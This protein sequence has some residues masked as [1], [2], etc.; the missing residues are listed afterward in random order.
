MGHARQQVLYEEEV[1]RRKEAGEDEITFDDWQKKQKEKQDA[2]KKKEKEDREK[3]EKEDRKEREKEARESLQ[4]ELD[5]EN[6]RRK[7]EGLEELTL[8]EWLKSKKR[9]LG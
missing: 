8:E 7:T 2:D 3:K 5:E 9:L 4:R 1:A 6:E